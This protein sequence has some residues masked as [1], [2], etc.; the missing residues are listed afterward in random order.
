MT[1]SKRDIKRKLQVLEYAEDCGN[2]ARTCRHFG[3][4]RQCYYNW[5]RAHERFGEAGLVNRGPCPE[6]RSLR[7]PAAIDEK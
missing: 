4:S 2:V 6:N 3:I 5:R 7:T 1:Q